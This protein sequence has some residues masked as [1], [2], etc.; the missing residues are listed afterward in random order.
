YGQEAMY[1]QI[2]SEDGQVMNR[3]VQGGEIWMAPVLPGVTVELR[4]KLRRGLSINGKSKL[5]MKVT[6]GAAGIIF[7]ARGRPLALPRPKDR[8]VRFAKWQLAMMGRDARAAEAPAPPSPDE[9]AMP[10]LEMEGM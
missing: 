10:D 2:R 1:I 6:A 4:L 8:A 7:D 3:T 9:L 5:R